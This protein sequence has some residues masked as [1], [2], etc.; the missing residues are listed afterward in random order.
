M[1]L[2]AAAP[3]VFGS[4]SPAFAHGFGQRYDLPLPLPLYLSAAAAAVA[5][6]FV[7]ISLFVRGRTGPGHNPHLNLLHTRIGRLLAHP[8]LATACKSVSVGLFFLAILTGFFGSERPRDNLTPTLVWVIWWVGLAYVS[9]LIGNL[10]ALINPWKVLFSWIE[11]LSPPLK[12]SGGLSL[13]LPYPSWLGVWPGLLLFFIFAWIELAY[14]GRTQPA[15]LAFFIILYSV[16]TWLGMFLFGKERWCQSGEAFSI[17][18]SLLARFAPTEVRV[19]NP[20]RCASCSLDCR[21]ARGQCIN[22]YE[23]FA[24]A[25]HSDRE[26]NLRPFAAGLLREETVSLS[27]AGFTILMLATVTFDG[28]TATPVWANLENLLEELFGFLKILPFLRQ[29]SVKSL[30]LLLFPTIFVAVYLSVCGLMVAVSGAKVPLEEMARIFVFSLI[31]ISL[32][33]HLAHYLSYLLI[34]GQLIIP[35]LSDPFG[36]GWDLWATANYQINIAIVG[37]RFTWWMSVV[38]IVMGHIIAVYLAHVIALRSLPEQEAALRSQYPM[39][40]LMVG[41]TVVSLWIIAQPI[42]ESSPKG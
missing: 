23:C 24:S 7:V 8:V 17:A 40:A 19:T 14:S 4:F 5:L 38:S 9:A 16:T 20:A 22:C 34:Q 27:M 35:L 32:A 33:Y 1:I 10:W 39:L 26:L 13:K 6:S 30:A 18:F 11:A 37:A 36:Y 42:V 28:F 12:P 31:P 25:E 41:Y 3:W 2:L 15:N 21:D 29:D